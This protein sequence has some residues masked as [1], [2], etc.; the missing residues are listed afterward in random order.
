MDIN[1]IHVGHWY[2]RI[3]EPNRIVKVTQVGRYVAFDV[4][5]PRHGQGRRD[6]SSSTLR[7]DVF[8]RLYQPR[9]D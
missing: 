8:A 4:I 6:V 2:Q 5:G 7:P 1:N 3:D 9:Q